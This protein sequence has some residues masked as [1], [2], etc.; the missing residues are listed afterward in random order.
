MFQNL[1]DNIELNNKDVKVNNKKEII[2]EIFTIQ[3][4]IIY[5]ISFLISTVSIKDGISPFAIAFFVAA[6]SSTIPAGAVLI[7]T[8]LGVLVGLGPGELL[9]YF[10]T[11]LMFFVS[12]IFFK[13]Y[14]QDDRN[15]ITKLGKNLIIASIVVKVIKLA[16]GPVL[17]YDA[18]V[19][20]ITIIIEYAFYKIFVNSIG[21]IEEF[22]LRSAFSIEE[23]I[24]ATVLVAIAAVSLAKYRFFGISIA[25]VLSIFLILVLAWRNGV[26]VGSTIGISLGLI[27]G[28]IGQI[29]PLQV[30]SLSISG[31]IGGLL[32]KLGKI[33]VILGFLV[34][35][36]V[37][38]YISTGAT[39]Q[40]VLYKEILIS[41]IGLMVLPKRVAI[42]VDDLVEK[43]KFFAPVFDNRLAESR[44]AEDR[45]SYLSDTVK[46]I[47]QSYGIQDEDLVL[48]EIEK[49]YIGF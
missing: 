35:N 10:L 17:V 12:V 23:I 26:L 38:S 30:L 1:A 28:V 6:C 49:K 27:L 33:G 41:A 16:I 11:I 19:S 21:V 24:G 39:I 3:N 8:S 40:V 29:T 43:N 4:I 48:D 44:N 2:K 7:T 18:I 9:S 47:A 22:G 15:E 13:P 20:F 31:M 5:I 25:N 45:L 34:G 14:V 37:L 42:T 36:A 46:E 32:N